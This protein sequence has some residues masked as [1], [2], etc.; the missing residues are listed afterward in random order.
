MCKIDVKH[1]NQTQ[2]SWEH[3]V[4]NTIYTHY[5]GQCLCNVVLF[6][7]TIYDK[8]MLRYKHIDI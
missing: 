4:T 6:E 3:Y 1:T 7:I 8:D 2:L 5:V